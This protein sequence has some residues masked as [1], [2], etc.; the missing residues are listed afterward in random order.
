AKNESYAGKEHPSA[1]VP[2][3]VIKKPLRVLLVAGGPTHDFQFLRT[4]LVREKD[5]RRAELSIFLQNQGRDSRSVPDVEPERLLSRFPSAM[6]T[7]DDP[8]EKPDD[9]YYNLARYDVIIA[10]DPDW[11]EFTGEQLDLIK[12]W[13]DTQAGGLVVVAGPVNTF[14]LARG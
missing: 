4:L 14:Q 9:R 7:E 13:V 6:R 11:S 5:A 10:Y 3:Q 8:A 2:V 12:R 1:P